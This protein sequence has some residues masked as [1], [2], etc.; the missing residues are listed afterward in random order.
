[1]AARTLLFGGMDEIRRRS[2]GW[3]MGV[4]VFTVM[5]AS[6]A[7][8]SMACS[9]PATVVAEPQSDEDE[10]R[11]PDADT[12]PKSKSTEPDAAVAAGRSDAV[13]AG[14]DASGDAGKVLRVFVTSQTVNAKLGGFNA[15][16]LRCTNLATMAGIPG[17]WTAWL[18]AKDGPHAVD[19]ITGSGPWHLRTGELVAPDKASLLSGSLQHAIDHDENGAAVAAGRVWTGTGTDGRFLTN[20]C[21]RWTTGTNGRVGNSGATNA[22]WTTADVVNCGS[23][24]R[25]YCFERSSIPLD[26]TV[27]G[28]E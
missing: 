21:D 27:R 20:D 12:D 22:S 26:R 18:S 15:A 11:D 28:G 4:F 14:A 3:R 10:T 6:G 19:R 23:A 7:C 5:L 25:L 2:A 1:M 13:D 24:G 8:A 17:L 16:D 9:P